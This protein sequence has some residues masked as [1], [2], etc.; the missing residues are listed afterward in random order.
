MRC[1]RSFATCASSSSPRAPKKDKYRSLLRELRAAEPQERTALER[2]T[3]LFEGL[4]KAGHPAEEDAAPAAE[5]E[6]Q[7]EE[8]PVQKRSVRQLLARHLV[9]ERMVHD[10]A[11]SE[12]HGECRGQDLRLIAEETSERY[13]FI[14]ASM[15]VIEDV[16]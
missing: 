2:S 3:A 8:S 14:P 12:K 10:L 1:T 15:K 4:W 6:R 9:L 5:E 16:R 13:K 11:E 7:P